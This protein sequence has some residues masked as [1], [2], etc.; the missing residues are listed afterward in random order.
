MRKIYLTELDIH[1]MI[2]ESVQA[3]LLEADNRIK[4]AR[5]G[6]ARYLKKFGNTEEQIKSA[7]R[8]FR[9]D[10][11]GEGLMGNDK[12]E[13][14]Q[15]APMFC[16]FAVEKGWTP[17][18][19]VI[20]E[21][22]KILFEIVIHH[23]KDI[24][25]LVNNNTDKITWS[26]IHDKYQ[27]FIDKRQEQENARISQNQYTKDNRYNYKIYGPLTFEQAKKFGDY[28]KPGGEICYTQRECTWN[29]GS[30]TKNNT[31]K[32]YVLVLSNWKDIPCEHTSDGYFTDTIHGDPIPADNNGYDL[33]GMSM[34]FLIVDKF[35]N[36]VVSNTRWNHGGKGR[37]SNIDHMFT[38]EDIYKL[39]GSKADDI[40]NTSY[41]N[42]QDALN[43]GVSIEEL[44]DDSLGVGN[45]YIK[46]CIGDKW[47]IL[48]NNKQILYKPNNPEQWFDS[49]GY[50]DDN[51]I[52]IVELNGK[53]TWLSLDGQL[54]DYDTKQPLS[55]EQVQELFQQQQQIDEIVNRLVRNY[56]R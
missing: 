29:S 27:P 12:L 30:Y 16:K 28:S 20:T 5:N 43:K 33:Y 37:E 52:A 18:S 14:L 45:G 19:G 23:K 38:K 40:F 1:Q 2:K 11:Y 6:C 8:K 31:R 55:Q 25:E 49:I 48:D 56:L 26:F 36:L 51:G 53:M 4:T 42:I 21:V 13:T 39:I 44:F 10:F 22:K 41:Q 17:T 15:L 34:I 46:V 32:V 3:L 35:G 24:P 47:T 50:F 7:F 54:L 9:E